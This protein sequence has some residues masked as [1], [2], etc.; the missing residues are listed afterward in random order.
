M[1]L[2]LYHSYKHNFVWWETV[3]L[4]YVLGL[5]LV[6]VM[7]TQLSGPDRLA[8]FIALIM[9]FLVLNMAV[10]PHRFVT[11]YALE[12]VSLGLVLVAAYLLQFAL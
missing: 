6:R 10:K 4:V 8:V 11:V 7:G 2:F 1:F 9:G 3:K 12:V 5:V